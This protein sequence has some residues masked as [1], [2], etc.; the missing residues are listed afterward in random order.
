MASVNHNFVSA[1]LEQ[2]DSTLVGPVEWNAGHVAVGAVNAVITTDGSG[3]LTYSNSF[4]YS[5]SLLTV[6]ASAG[7]ISG[8]TTASSTLTLQSTSGTG[9]SDQ[10]IF[11]T[12]SQVSAGFFDTGGNLNLNFKAYI[13]PASGESEL[14]MH[15]N[16]GFANFIS[17]FKNNSLRWAIDHGNGA[18]ETGSNVGTDWQIERYNDSGVFIDVP[19]QITRS[20]G[21]VSVTNSFQSPIIAGGSTASS[22]LTV[23][24]TSGAGTTDAII[25][26]TAS[27]SERARFISN[28]N[29]GFGD[30]NPGAQLILS[31]NAASGIAVG[32]NTQL[33]IIPADASH[34]AM[35]IDAYNFNEGFYRVRIAGGSGASPSVV[36]S[37][38]TIGHFTF[39]G[40]VSAGTWYDG[41]DIIGVT[42]ETYSGTA[43][44][45]ELRFRTTPVTTQSISEA[46]RID[47]A[48]NT[49]V[50]RGTLGYGTGVG[51]TITQ[52]TSRSTGV[53][54]NKI[55]G[56]ITLVSAAGSA[57]A[58][59]FTVSNTT[60]ASTDTVIVNQAS[61]TDKYEI[62]VTNITGGTSFAITFFTTGGTTTE[63]PVF[64]FAIIKAVTS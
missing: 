18:S 7:V 49:Q 53:T 31:K 55:C 36:T 8:G 51:G 35:F 17:G 9:T 42:A 57:S 63:Q 21:L 1:K 13:A 26:K 40:W 60:I 54:I 41:A 3:N 25:F 48:G 27:Q 30:T 47:N 14:Q 45:T 39:S 19:F 4:T 23:E 59:T 11:K 2:A 22:T 58:T 32:S 44:G 37:G 12:G 50:R 24:S 15:T 28:G 34:A 62:F 20:T 61:G 46:L 16:T 38:T 10:I 56:A 6:A 33:G 52:T 43:G 5:A 29:L 64:N